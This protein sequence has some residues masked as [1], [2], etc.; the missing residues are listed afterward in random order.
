[1]QGV[2]KRSQMSIPVIINN[3]QGHKI[4]SSYAVTG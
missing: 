2:T 1:M 4:Y 3:Q